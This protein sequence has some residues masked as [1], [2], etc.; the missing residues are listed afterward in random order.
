MRLLGIPIGVNQ[1]FTNAVVQ[2]YGN[3]LGKHSLLIK[4]RFTWLAD[5]L[6]GLFLAHKFKCHVCH[7]FVSIRRLQKFTSTTLEYNPMGN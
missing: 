3:Q 7:N 2:R 1:L 5:E 6:I 4:L